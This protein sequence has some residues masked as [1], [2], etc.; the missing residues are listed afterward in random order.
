MQPASQSSSAAAELRALRL[1]KLRRLERRSERLLDYIPRASPDLIAPRHLGRLASLFE[2]IRRGEVVRALVD[3]PA[4]HG[5]TTTSAHGIPY[6]LDERPSWP[7]AYVTF[8]QQQ[9]NRK[10]LDA[11]RIALRSGAL[12]EHA[13]RITFEEW[14][15][16]AGGGCIFTGIGGGLGGNPVRVLVFDDFFK[17]REEAESQNRRDTVADWITSV[18]IPRLPAEGSIII[19]STRWHEDDPSGRIQRGELCAGM[20]WEH[21]SL[22]FLSNEKGEPDDHGDV[23]LW[24]KEHRPDGTRVG[25]TAEEAR[26][27]L[28]EV[29]PHDA[30]SIY[31][32]QPRP[33]GGT[34]Y[35]QP[36]RCDAPTLTGA[37]L[38]IGADCAGT[39][40]PQSNHS[41]FVA[42]AVRG[43]GATMAADLAGVLR[44]KL[45]PEHAAPQ[46]LA[47]QR[48]FGG[49][50]LHI[51]ATRDGRDLGAAL[52]RIA[53]GLV[54]R[55][56]AATGD[57]FLRAQ[58]SA[59]AWNTG[60]IRVPVDCRTM[61]STTDDDL[62]SFVRV[63]TRFSGMGDAHDDDVD[64]LSHA[65]ACAASS[66][67]PTTGPIRGF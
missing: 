39:D 56:V 9:A 61:R 23:V 29:G 8:S 38:V 42:L 33:R 10:S 16:P 54:I 27:R 45:R 63:V 11:Q 24:P 46:V 25:W 13:D 17:N 1:E 66:A 34:V 58:P 48:G 32:G 41:V 50:P 62:A 31:Q 5:K 40:G 19:P 37:R 12:D 15:K 18:A 21:V 35:R 53:P 52:Q 47:W 64:A 55:Y 44:L 65:W 7:L 14:R 43:Y 22:P 4:Q 67:P 60:R 59:A 51:E 36:D 2:R 26:A 30:A 6:I 49:T 3:V 57:K 28:R 20:A